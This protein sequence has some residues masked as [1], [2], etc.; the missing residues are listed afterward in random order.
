MRAEVAKWVNL[1][2]EGFRKDGF[3][4]TD[5]VATIPRALDGVE[6]AVRNGSTPM[7]VLITEAMR[8]EAGTEIAIFNGGSIRIDDVL[9]AGP[10]TQ[11]DVIRVLPFGGKILKATFTGALLARVLQ[12]G[13]QNKGTGGF[14][15]YVGVPALDPN[16]RYTLAISD[17]L[18][19]G[20][21]ANLGFL[22]RQNPEISD[23]TEFRDIRLALIDELKRQ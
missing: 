16:A 11:Y 18:M 20:G 3:E 7:T 12:V 1:G 23:V 19:T 9:Q 8:R 4:P 13:E 15:H 5:V 22:T 21:E 6:A 2:F 17:F 14:L 10:I